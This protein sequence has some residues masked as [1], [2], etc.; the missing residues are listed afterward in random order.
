MAA[1][2]L[3]LQEVTQYKAG[4]RMILMMNYLL[5][6]ESF[7]LPRNNKR[8]LKVKLSLILEVVDSVLISKTVENSA[9]QQ[10]LRMTMTLRM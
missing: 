8:L 3:L 5:G 9:G 7:P 4:M 10:P 6:I 1:R 2:P